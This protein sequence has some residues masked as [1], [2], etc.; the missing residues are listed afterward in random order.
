MHSSDYGRGSWFGQGW[1]RTG[2]LLPL[3]LGIG[4]G[5]LLV[6]LLP[7][8]RW[9]FD[10][11][12]GG[13][14][15][16]GVAAPGFQQQPAPRAERIPHA[17]PRHGHGWDRSP[18]AHATPLWGLLFWPFSAMRLIA[19]LLLIGLGA[20]LLA[21]GRRGGGSRGSPTEGASHSGQAGTPQAPPVPPADLQPPGPPDA[22]STGET[23]RL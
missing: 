23:R 3:L 19:P 21:G 15:R 7:T 13:R 5:A 12:M 17:H 6:G 1:R 20:W 22:P 8:M 4:I 16:R 10:G 2:W 18:F 14:H 9:G 11:H